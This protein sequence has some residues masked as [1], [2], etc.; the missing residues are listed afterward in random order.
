M[1]EVKPYEYYPVYNHSP[2]FEINHP[3]PFLPWKIYSSLVNLPQLKY[4]PPHFAFSLLLFGPI[5]LEK[6]SGSCNLDKVRFQYGARL[7]KQLLRWTLKVIGLCLKEKNRIFYQKMKFLQKLFARVWSLLNTNVARNSSF[8]EDLR[9]LR[10]IFG[11][12]SSLTLK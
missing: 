2:K 6:H 11:K 1:F 5:S 12:I 9:V 7:R 8:Y 3:V 4:K 10:S